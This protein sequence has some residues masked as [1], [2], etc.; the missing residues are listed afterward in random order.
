MVKNDSDIIETADPLY[1]TGN[2]V[3]LKYMALEDPWTVENSSWDFLEKSWT[4]TIS[5]PAIGAE[6]REGRAFE[7]DLRLVSLGRK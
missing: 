3:V 7:N 5:K 2:M 6:I 1:G 4:Y